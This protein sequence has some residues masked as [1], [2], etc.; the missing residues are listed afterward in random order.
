MP[1]RQ[2]LYAVLNRVGL[3]AVALF[4]ISGGLLGFPR[5]AA[6]Q[7]AG[8][9]QGGAPYIHSQAGLNPVPEHGSSESASQIEQMRLAERQR[10]IAADTAQLAQ[11]TNELKAQIDQAPKDQIS[12]DMLRKA[13]EIEKLAHDLNGWLKY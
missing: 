11:L 6:G 12:V 5:A 13:A 7:S 2:S 4:A 10:R 3:H 9:N 8:V 1:V